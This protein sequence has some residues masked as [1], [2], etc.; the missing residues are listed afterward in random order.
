MMSTCKECRWFFQ[1]PEN[2][3]DY[4]PG[5]GDCVTEK[6]DSKGKYYLSKPTVNTSE[7]CQQFKKRR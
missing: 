5:K 3:G 1:V 2:A 7:S 4:Q 6:E